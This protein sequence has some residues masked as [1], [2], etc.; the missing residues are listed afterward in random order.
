MENGVFTES[1]SKSSLRIHSPDLDFA[2]T[3]QGAHAFVKPRV[4]FILYHFILTLVSVPF[5]FELTS[6]STRWPSKTTS[7]LLWTKLNCM[8]L[9]LQYDI[10]FMS[11]QFRIHLDTISCLFRIHFDPTSPS[12]HSYVD[13]T[14]TSHASHS[15]LSYFDYTSGSF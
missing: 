3:T 8:L 12:L 2:C 1:L 6:C 10:K 7:I 5:R 9:S 15:A 13:Y 11:L 14:P 4:D